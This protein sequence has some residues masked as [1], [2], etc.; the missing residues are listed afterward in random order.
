[1]LIRKQDYQL[2][3]EHAQKEAP[4]EACGA[5][6]GKHENEKI[7]VERVVKAKNIRESPVEYEISAEEILEIYRLAEVLELEVV[8]FYHSHPF[9]G[10]LWSTVDDER[11]KLWINHLFLIYSVAQK[12]ARCYKRVAENRVEE[13]PIEIV[14]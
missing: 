1:M 8:G 13:E 10:P 9:H 5:L 7:V 2:I 12:E 11:S 14:E 3:A 4:N 6:L